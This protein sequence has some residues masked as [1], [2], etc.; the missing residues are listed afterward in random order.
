MTPKNASSLDKRVSKSTASRSLM[1]GVICVCA[2]KVSILA[3]CGEACAA[4]EAVMGP[5][6]LDAFLDMGA[7]EVDAGAESATARA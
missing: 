4:P 3:I 5:P 7:F 1:D 6:S 2:I